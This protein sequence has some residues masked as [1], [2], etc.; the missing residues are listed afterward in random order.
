MKKSNGESNNG[1]RLLIWPT[2][3]PDALQEAEEVLGLMIKQVFQLKDIVPTSK[4]DVPAAREHTVFAPGQANGLENS[5]F[6]RGDTSQ[7]F[8]FTELFPTL[9]TRGE[10]DYAEATFEEAKQVV[11]ELGNQAHM[12]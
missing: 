7:S 1:H 10:F 4:P 12:R 9:V 8:S 6:A 5:F 11:T 3:P 2:D